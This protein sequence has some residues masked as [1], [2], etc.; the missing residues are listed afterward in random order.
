MKNNNGSVPILI[1]LDPR[2]KL[3]MVI[4]LTTVTYISKDLFVLAW[5]YSLI[6]F[7]YIFSGLM[8]NAAKTAAVLGSLV[9]LEVVLGL[10]PDG[11]AVSSLIFL[12]F[13]IERTL[14]F[15][16]MSG[17]MSNTIKITD[18]V[19]ALQNIHMP[20]GLTITLAVVFRYLPTVSEEFAAIKKTMRLRNIEPSFINIVCHPVRMCEYSIVPLII[21]SMK[22]ADELSASAMTRGLD[23]EGKRTSYKEV[24]LGF[25]DIAVFLVFAA[26]VGA[27]M[28]LDV[29]I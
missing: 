5:N 22:I 17:W 28:Y 23:L 1:A 24:R 10:L 2:I 26:A 25:S 4:F 20:K 13:I 9:A 3:L 11:G 14:V 27:G 6:V 16:V 15:F 29:L 8:K 18:L 19:T 21:R 12:V 7:L